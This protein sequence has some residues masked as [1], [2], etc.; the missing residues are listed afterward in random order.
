MLCAQFKFSTTGKEKKTREDRS[1]RA[2][3]K[4]RQGSTDKAY[5]WPGFSEVTPSRVHP[6]KRFDDRVEAILV[7]LFVASM[8]AAMLIGSV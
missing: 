6:P 3:Q 7:W 4:H 8:I 1:T 2:G 5:G